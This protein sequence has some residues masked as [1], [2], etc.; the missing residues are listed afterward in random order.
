MYRK[1]TVSEGIIS[2]PVARRLI[3]EETVLIRLKD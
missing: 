2:V 1:K 3:P